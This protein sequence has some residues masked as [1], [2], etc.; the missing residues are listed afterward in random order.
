VRFTL[1]PWQKV[2]DPEAL[3]E[4]VETEGKTV[5]TTGEEVAE[6]PEEVTVTV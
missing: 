1:P 6:Q 3:M 4:G 5:T 2:S